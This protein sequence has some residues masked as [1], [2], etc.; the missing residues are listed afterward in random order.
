MADEGFV[1]VA[2]D[3]TGKRIANFAVT[4]PAG[5]VV[6]NAD[7]STTTLAVDTPVFLQRVVIGDPSDGLASLAV[8]NVTPWPDEGGAVVRVVGAGTILKALGRIED[9]LERLL[10][11]R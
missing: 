5:T 10:K 9:L 1:Q 4:L 8:K 11:K 6:T 2:V 3:S 7:G